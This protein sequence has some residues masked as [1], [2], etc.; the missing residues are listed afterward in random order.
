MGDRS[1][2]RHQKR[3]ARFLK[4]GIDGQN[5]A[6]R[7]GDLGC[8]VEAQ[9][10]SLRIGRAGSAREGLEE[11]LERERRGWVPR[12]DNRQLEGSLAGERLYADGSVRRPVLH[13]VPDKVGKELRDTV[14]VAID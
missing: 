12:I 5:P 10:Q 1:A 13:G 2:Q 6:V 14:A 4:G 8:D 3:E 7:P 9:S 11:T